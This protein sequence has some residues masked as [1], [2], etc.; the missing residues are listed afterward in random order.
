M[1][2]EY[3]ID[4]SENIINFKEF[5]K[6]LFRNL[7]QIGIFSILGI[8]FTSILLI[9]SKKLYT[10][11]FQI[12]LEG[13]KKSSISE[14]K[15]ALES[16]IGL[17]S[18]EGQSFKTELEILKSPFVL[19]N[20]FEFIQTYD[21]V[22]SNNKITFEDWSKQIEAKF[23][24]STTVLNVKY[25]DKNKKNILPVLK[26]ISNSYQNYSGR[27]RKREL[28][29]SIDY[30]QKQI[31]K[32]KIKSLVANEESDKF[33][34]KHDLISFRKGSNS[35]NSSPGSTNI[36]YPAGEI[37]NIE[38]LRTQK[39]TQ[40]RELNEFIKLVEDNKDNPEQ[41]LNLSNLIDSFYFGDKTNINK[42]NEKIKNISINLSSLRETYKE[43]DKL[44]QSALK[45]RET[46]YKSLYKDIRNSLLASKEKSEASL[47]SLIRPSG[48]ISKYKELIRRAG[49]N[50]AILTQLE[51]QLRIYS[52][53]DAKYK[54]PWQLITNPKL[55][56]FAKPQYKLRKLFIGLISGFLIGCL[57]TKLREKIR[58]KIIS[59]FDIANIFE[60]TWIETFELSNKDS[61]QESVD[62]LTNGIL[63]NFE[64]G[65]KMLN[66]DIEDKKNLMLLLKVLN[67]NSRN[68]K[69]TC[70]DSALDAFEENNFLICIESS[71]TSIKKLEKIKKIISSQNKNLIGILFINK[72]YQ[73]KDY[74]SNNKISL[75]SSS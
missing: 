51:D 73:F 66:I 34:E 12:V 38:G 25:H 26:K 31:E 21:P 48:V 61:W 54:D 70:T 14:A 36:L 43:N 39:S 40:I 74:F 75:I 69:I 6:F 60:E 30:F 16:L 22:Y 4:Y 20:V 58:N 62:F 33:A 2:R 19:L 63:S 32:Y 55:D 10:G 8:L 15:S 67:K 28:E 29:I 3:E 71:S 27:R 17:S 44:I 45:R 53:E 5:F 47:K 13:E 11:Q 46:L 64:G 57:I 37:L 52:L 35:L 7:K 72:E 23:K 50:E 41:I 56:K 49:R 9:N 1:V 65:I 42:I 68:L 18:A 59:E 24:L